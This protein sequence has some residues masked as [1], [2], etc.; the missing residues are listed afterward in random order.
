MAKLIKKNEAIVIIER[1]KEID[2]STEWGDGFL[3]GLN[4]IEENLALLE[5]VTEADI[6]A[7]AISDMAE[8]I[9]S[10]FIFTDYAQ[11]MCF[12]D[13]IDKLAE[14]LKKEDK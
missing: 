6:R 7:K 14:Q 12:K 8:A 1:E 10:N 9:K 2:T 13:M 11:A 5:T 3:S 4:A